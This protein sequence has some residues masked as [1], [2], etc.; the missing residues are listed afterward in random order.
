MV[1]V[2]TSQTQNWDASLTAL[3]TEMKVAGGDHG[4]RAA[5]RAQRMF[6]AAEL[7]ILAEMKRTGTSERE[8]RRKASAG[9]TRSKKSAARKKKQ[10]D[11]VEE[12][13]DLAADIE[14][15][16]LGEEQLDAIAE[17][18]SKT[19]GE[20][21]NDTSLIRDIKN[22][23]PE[24]ASSIA[25]RWL[26]ARNDDGTR[27]RHERQRARRSLRFGYDPASGCESVTAT[28]DNESIR[29]IERQVKSL[30]AELYRKDGGRDVPNDKHPRTHQQRMYDAFHQL[31][32]ETRGAAATTTS[33][34]SAGTGTNVRNM[35]HVFITVDDEDES[36]IRAQAANGEG[37][38]PTSV[39]DRYGCNA[40]IGGTVFTRR[41]EVLWHGRQK[42]SATPSQVAALIIRDRGCVLCTADPSRCEAHHLDPFTSLNKG[43]TNVEDMALVCIDCHHWL[44][45][46]LMTLY[47]QLGPPDSHGN[48]TREWRTRP[49]T[50]NEVA[51]GRSSAGKRSDTGKPHDTPGG[52]RAA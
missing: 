36:I 41:G 12:N 8:A 23:A 4:L 3:C 37:Y 20:A 7:S 49:A 28:G 42:R 16:N 40:M 5:Q 48:H 14:Q 15:G 39:L 26:E 46:E 44:H 13:P 19:N 24:Q 32:T 34:S 43:E 21:A 27:S 17:A 22:A 2:G 47:W 18:S 50:A 9:G 11:T 51:R 30:A 35:M 33:S 45:E 1:G 10:S 52:R 31:L 29:E 6:A 25:S 38:I